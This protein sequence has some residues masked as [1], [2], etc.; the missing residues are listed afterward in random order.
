MDSGSGE[1]EMFVS[2]RGVVTPMSATQ[3]I[4][5]SGPPKNMQ[6]DM[7]IAMAGLSTEQAEEIF[8]LTHE[9]KKLGRKTCMTLLACQVRKCCSTWGLRL[10]VTKKLPVGT[11]TVLQ[12]TM[13]FCSLKKRRLK[14]SMKQLTTC[15]NRQVGYS[16]I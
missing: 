3:F 9:A 11:L 1:F 15:A 4:I 10:L 8:L 12:P 6:L 13:Q 5:S 7:A 14:I 16:W 2:L